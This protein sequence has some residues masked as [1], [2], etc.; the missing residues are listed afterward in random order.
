MGTTTDNFTRANQAGLGTTPE[1]FV[2]RTLPTETASFAISTNQAEISNDGS[3]SGHFTFIDTLAPDGNAS[4]TLA[5]SSPYGQ[6]LYF[7]ITDANNWWRVSYTG[8]SYSYEVG[9]GYTCTSTLYY[10]GDY[11]YHDLTSVTST[12]FQSSTDQS[13]LIDPYE[14]PYSYQNT[15]CSPNY[16]TV[17][18]TNYTVNLER[19][20]AGAIT[21]VSQEGVAATVTSLTVALLGSQI[22]AGYNAVTFPVATSAFNVSATR[23]GLG[24]APSSINSSPKFATQFVANTATNDS[25]GVLMG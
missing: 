18:G 9:N 24:S 21:I 1:G 16:S 22:T 6:A 8:Y 2:W 13:G 25:V 5:S 7:R 3:G 23:F 20:T 19:C 12:T 4:L 11:N 15:A 14:N 17:T 10:Y